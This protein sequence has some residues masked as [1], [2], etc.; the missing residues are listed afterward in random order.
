MVADG[1]V[2]NQYTDPEDY[3]RAAFELIVI[4]FAL[5][6]FYGEL[7]EFIGG[8]ST[9]V[10]VEDYNPL[11]QIILKVFF[12]KVVNP[13]LVSG[14]CAKVPRYFFD[15]WNYLDLLTYSLIIAATIVRIISVNHIEP[16]GDTERQLMAISRP[17]SPSSSLLLRF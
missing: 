10:M 12:K 7:R 6:K 15:G 13:M 8:G 17:S 2:L 16:V 3:V 4:L 11:M 1:R 14:R 5:Y 9:F